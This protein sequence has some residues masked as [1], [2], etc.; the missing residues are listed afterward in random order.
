MFDDIAVSYTHLDV[1][2]RQVRTLPTKENRDRKAGFGLYYHFDYHGSPVSYEWVNST[3][4]P[5]VWEQ[6]TMAY[7]YGI[8]DL[9]IVNV[10]DIRPQELPLSYYMALAYDYEGMGINHPNETDD[11]IRGWVEEQFG[12]VVEDDDVKEEIVAVLKAY[13]RTVSYTH[14][15]TSFSLSESSEVQA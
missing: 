10:G 11:F 8:K 2:K 6:L 7:E 14:L 9:W 1:Y 3:P 5:K 4:L 13:T 15:S 12:G